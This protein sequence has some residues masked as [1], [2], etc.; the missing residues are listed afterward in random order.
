MSPGTPNARSSPD[1]ASREF[2]SMV[3]DGTPSA[4]TVSQTAQATSASASSEEEPTVSRSHWVIS[5]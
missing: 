2:T 3:N 5:R 4:A 1:S